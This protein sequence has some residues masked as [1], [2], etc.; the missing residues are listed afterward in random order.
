MENRVALVTDK[1]LALTLD[2]SFSVRYA[3]ASPNF[4]FKEGN[5]SWLQ[6]PKPESNH[7]QLLFLKH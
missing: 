7:L 3:L 2:F 1:Q 4:I 5:N 6:K